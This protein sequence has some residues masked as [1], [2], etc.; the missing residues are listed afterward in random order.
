MSNDTS[1]QMSYKRILLKLSGEALMGDQKFGHDA[2]T[3]RGFCVDI[4]EAYDAGHQICLV[5]GGGNICRGAAAATMGIERATADYMGMLATV[6]N[7]L[8]IQS[9]LES[10]GIETRVQSAISMTA[11]CEP[12]IRRRAVRHMEKG[13]LVIFASGTGSP[14]FT[15][16]TAAALKAAEM[17][18]DVMLKGTQVSGVYS[19]DPKKD[20]EAVYYKSIDYKTVLNQD[21]KAM[22][23]AA[24]T[25]ARENKIPIIVFDIR[26]KSG[27][28]KVLSGQGEF[29]IISE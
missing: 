24:I 19:A 6:I 28:M 27:L 17:N 11:I 2:E 15:T 23:A 5:V 3:I 10:L 18:C 25:I 21:L 22:D 20:P 4:K 14:F 13:R 1:Q 7:A 9:M 12:Y 26:E 16:D 8:A 29:T